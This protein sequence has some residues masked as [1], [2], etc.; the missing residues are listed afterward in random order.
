MKVTVMMEPWV[1]GVADS[2]IVRLVRW[3]S[4]YHVFAV[5]DLTERMRHHPVIVDWVELNIDTPVEERFHWFEPLTCVTVVKRLIGLNEWWVM[6][7]KQL[8]KRLRYGER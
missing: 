3:W 2:W 8:M 6:T 4:K 7:P 1:A 5:L